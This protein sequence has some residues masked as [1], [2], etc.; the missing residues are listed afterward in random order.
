[1]K[2]S[3]KV[4]FCNLILPR[5]SNL[6]Q[7]LIKKQRCICCNQLILLHLYK[8]NKQ[9]LKIYKQLTSRS[10]FYSNSYLIIHYYVL[11]QNFSK[12]ALLPVKASQSSRVVSCKLKPKIHKN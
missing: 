6:L 11:L 10:K 8:T 12:D 4:E 5:H 2:L 9:K 3:A 1:M 7:F